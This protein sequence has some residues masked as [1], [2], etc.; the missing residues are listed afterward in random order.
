MSHKFLGMTNQKLI[1]IHYRDPKTMKNPRRIANQFL[2]K[3]KKKGVCPLEISY[4]KLPSYDVTHGVGIT[5]IRR[6]KIHDFHKFQEVIAELE[7]E[8]ERDKTFK[9]DFYDLKRRYENGK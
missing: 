9:I 4:Y 2:R 5:V 8:M 7:S 3:L 1:V 6:P